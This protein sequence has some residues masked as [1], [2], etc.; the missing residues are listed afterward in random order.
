M[1]AGGNLVTESGVTALGSSYFGDDIYLNSGAVSIGLM[2]NVGNVVIF[3]TTTTRIELGGEATTVNIGAV[4]GFGNTTVRNDLTVNGGLFLTGGWGEVGIGNV[5]INHD[6]DV[7]NTVYANNISL[8]NNISAFGAANITGNIFTGGAITAT[9]VYTSSLGGPLV[10]GGNVTAAGNLVTS[11]GGNNS[12]SGNLA[13]SGTARSNSVT[14]GSFTTRGGAGIL[15]NLVVGAPNNSNSSVYINSI[16]QAGNTTSGALQVAGGAG[17]VGNLY[18]G[19][20]VTIGGNIN[21]TSFTSAAIDGTPIG[22]NIASTGRFTTVALT[23]KPPAKRPVFRFD[24]ANYPRLDQSLRLT[25]SGPGTYFN[26]LGKLT[27]AA[28]GAARFTHDPETLLSRGILIEE[29]RQNLYRE[30]N[31]FSNATVYSTLDATISSVAHATD[32]PTGEFDAWKVVEASTTGAHGVYQAPAYVPTVT[33]TQLYTASVFVKAGERDQVALVFFNE[34]T[35]SI[36]DLTAGTVDSEG[37]SY[38]SS[39]TPVGN[40]WYRIQSTITKTNT[41]GNVMI[42]PAVGGTIN[43]AGDGTSGFYAYGLQL[44]A[45]SFATSYIPNTTIA[46]TRTADVLTIVSHEFSKR[47]D[48]YSSTVVVDAA[49][50]YRPTTQVPNNLRST[51][52]SFND[53]T[54]SNRISILAENKNGPVDRTANLV[55][56]SGGTLISNAN[57][58]TANLTTVG[59]EKIAM[60]FSG[61]GA[62]GTAYSGNGNVTVTTAFTSTAMNQITI[63]S[64]PGSAALNGT[65]GKLAI[66]SGVVTG[67]E[68][69]TLTLK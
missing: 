51:L 19:G 22:G 34:G 16:I 58:S 2:S 61:I 18:V 24:F 37:A 29:T 1:I 28:A 14:T 3:P 38:N 48:A 9:G 12:I 21:F 60:Y 25:R 40:A 35:P 68:L 64:G 8:S 20:N 49:L 27:V 33:Q 56:Y 32:S 43:Y 6:L 54:A 39:I 17:I 50:D 65:I 7:A 26:E 47:Y 46:N 62:I 66:Y 4:S 44:E 52:V 10:V 59:S 63:G 30:S 36:F 67:Q 5:T 31:S 42:A 23:Q 15:G 13:L 55:I 69:K 57:I 53:G 45:G 41:S 11:G